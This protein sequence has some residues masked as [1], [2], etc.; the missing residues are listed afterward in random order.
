[1]ARRKVLPLEVVKHDFTHMVKTIARV[2]NSQGIIF[3]AALMDL[4]HLKLGDEGNVEVHNGGTITALNS[5]SSQTEVS[6]VIQS[7]M[8]D[9]A[10]IM[11]KL[12]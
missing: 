11:K 4:A 9:Y 3:E 5:R 10:K 7:T 12:A 6:K 1:M 2:G 8:E